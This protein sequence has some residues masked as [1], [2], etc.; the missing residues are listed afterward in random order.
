MNRQIATCIGILALLLWSTLVGMLRLSTEKFGPMYTVTYVYTLSAIILYFSYG[1]PD[2]K[3]VSKTFLICSSALFVVFETCF[4]FSI[5]LAQSSEKSIEMNIIFS[6]WP[7]L[8]IL[9]LAFL[10]EEKVNSLTI[11]GVIISFLGI[12]LINYHPS[13]NFIDSFS[14]NPVSYL[15]IFLAA[16]LWAIYCIYTKKHS[17][18]TNAISLYFILTAT[19]LWILTLSTQGFHIPHVT[20]MN[21]Y[22]FIAINAL[23]FA[24]GYLAWNVGIIKGNM[25]V[26]VM[27][28]Y[29]SPLLSSTFSVM[30]LHSNLSTYFW[31]GAAIVCFGSLI[32]WFSIRKKSIPQV[33]LAT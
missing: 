28:S 26:L 4:A 22:V 8:I 9:I 11:L 23:F 1:L 16:L 19:A 24:M 27:L 29:F 20:Q 21:S 10:K 17:N 18:G 14:K 31:Y 6:L 15:L 12:I 7:T 2:L 5:T 25:P 32:C 33:E 3:Q 13:L 30:V